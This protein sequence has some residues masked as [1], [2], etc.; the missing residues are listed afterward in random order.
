MSGRALRCLILVPKDD[1]VMV[2]VTECILPAVFLFQS[3]SQAPT[4]TLEEKRTTV[5]LV[6]SMDPAVRLLS[7]IDF[8]GVDDCDQFIQ[9]L[10]RC[11]L[12]MVQVAVFVVDYR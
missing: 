3:C 4:G 7:V 8:P 5:P 12:E 9:G 6:Y 11:M 1:S 2:K 10:C